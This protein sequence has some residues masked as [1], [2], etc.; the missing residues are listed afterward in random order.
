MIR[1]S[2]L[3]AALVGLPASNEAGGGRASVMGGK[4]TF[5]G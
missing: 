1:L 4:G 3:R 2:V 5:F